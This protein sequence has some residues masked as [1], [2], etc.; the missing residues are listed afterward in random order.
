MLTQQNDLSSLL[1]K[2]QMRICYTPDHEITDLNTFHVVLYSHD[3]IICHLIDF[4]SCQLRVKLGLLVDCLRKK[5]VISVKCPFDILSLNHTELWQL[6]CFIAFGIL[7]SV[8]WNCPHY[9]F[10]VS[11]HF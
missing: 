11:L 10:I 1:V 2:G 4:G 7:S 9:S 5:N 8:K 6:I 3:P